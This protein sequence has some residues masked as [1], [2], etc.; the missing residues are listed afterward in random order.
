MRGKVAKKLRREAYGDK[1]IRARAYGMTGGQVKTIGGK[2]YRMDGTIVCTD[3]RA[4]YQERKK[5][6]RRPD[7]A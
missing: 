7:A 3:E 6:R 1:S 2:R 5:E 4:D